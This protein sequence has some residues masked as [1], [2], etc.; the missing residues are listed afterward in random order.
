MGKKVLSDTALWV[1]LGSGLRS[2][3]VVKLSVIGGIHIW[4]TPQLP[5]KPAEWHTPSVPLWKEESLAWAWGRYAGRSVM[6]VR[7]R[8]SRGCRE[9]K[10]TAIWGDLTIAAAVQSLSRI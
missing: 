6:G 1:G 4:L 3:E 9:N 8:W 5:R 2:Q 10:R 7:C